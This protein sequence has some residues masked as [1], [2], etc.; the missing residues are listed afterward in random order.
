MRV[1]YNYD[2]NGNRT[3]KKSF[4][5]GSST[6]SEIIDLEYNDEE[7]RDRLKKYGGKDIRYEDACL[8]NPT[9]YGYGSQGI[10]FTWEGR[11]LINYSDNTKSLNI[12]YMYDAKG[13][14]A[15]KTVNGIITA[16][17]YEGNKLISEQKGTNKKY[18]LYDENDQ[19]Y[20]IIYNNV[21]YYYN[22]DI[23]GNILGIFDNFGN[24]VVKY[25]YDAYG[26]VFFVTGT[27]ANTL[28]KDNPFIYKG[29]YYDVETS[30][31]YCNSRYC[32]PEWGRWL[33]AD[34][35]SYLNPES[36]KSLNLFSYCGNNPVM[37]YD[38]MGT[39]N[40]GNFWKIA[41]GV[42]LIAGLVA[43]TIL[44][45]GALSVILA[46]AAIGAVGRGIGA[47]IST[48]ISGG[49]FDD[50]ADSF[51]TGTITGAISGAIASSPLGVAGQIGANVAIGMGSYAFT[52]AIGGKDITLGGLISNDVFG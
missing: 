28:G 40:W 35:V 19:L 43:G 3:S 27:M 5:L 17:S 47:G 36:V 1:E 46:G 10:M 45:G 29:Y 21:V 39:F 30:L 31:Y 44:T 11:R 12:S 6:P 22:R 50:F 4:T 33:N 24:D 14:R 41:G 23:L 48:A 26:I 52:Q 20:G 51:L 8:S 18:F 7:W 2:S 34:D 42:A 38:P 32:V 25:V 13:F 49:S 37:G 9:F 15:K 16:Y